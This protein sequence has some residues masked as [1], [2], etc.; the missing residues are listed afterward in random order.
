MQQFRGLVG[1]LMKIAS[2]LINEL[3]QKGK[4]IVQSA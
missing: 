2:L 1:K 3:D 4:M